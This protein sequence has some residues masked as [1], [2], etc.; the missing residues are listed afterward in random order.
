MKFGCKWGNRV[1]NAMYLY[2]RTQPDAIVT[3]NLAFH[4]SQA[5]H[6]EKKNV[7]RVC[8]RAYRKYLDNGSV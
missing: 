7:C 4:N 5:G 6:T 2:T 3:L 8:D 1:E